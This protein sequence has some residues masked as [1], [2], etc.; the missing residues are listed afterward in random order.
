MSEVEVS[1]FIAPFW[2]LPERGFH[3]CELIDARVASMEPFKRDLQF[4]V[5]RGLKCLRGEAGLDSLCERGC[6]CR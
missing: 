6:G 3:W 4:G 5:L 1:R 2:T